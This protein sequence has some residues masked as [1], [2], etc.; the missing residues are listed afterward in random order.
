MKK[1]LVILAALALLAMSNLAMAAS[2]DSKTVNVQL[3]VEKYVAITNALTPVKIVVPAGG[4]SGETWS[5]MNVTTN[6]SADL[7]AVVHQAAASITAGVLLTLNTALVSF[8]S[9]A[10]AAEVKIKYSVAKAT[11][12]T[13]A[14]M[15][16]F[17]DANSTNVVWTVAAD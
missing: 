9:P 12:L 17:N 11:M 1:M 13:I 6:C 8:D 15:D 7:T 10:D 4:N 14:D 2:T 5:T 3:T 16:A